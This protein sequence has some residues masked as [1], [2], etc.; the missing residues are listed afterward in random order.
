MPDVIATL[1]RLTPTAADR[2]DLLFQAGRASAP[3]RR[4]W[5]ALAA[6]L[7]LTNVATALLWFRDA[8]PSVAAAPPSPPP[9]PALDLGDVIPDIDTYRNLRKN[10]NPDSPPSSTADPVEPEATWRIWSARGLE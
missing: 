5:I 2:D 6:L 1:A 10:W 7:A 9:L 4:G 8:R 3:G